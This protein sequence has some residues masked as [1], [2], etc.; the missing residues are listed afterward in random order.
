[1]TLTFPAGAALPGEVPM[2]HRSRPATRLPRSRA[3]RAFARIGGAFAAL[4]LP[5]SALAETPRAVVPE[6]A[7]QWLHVSDDGGLALRFVLDGARPTPFVRRG[8]RATA[9]GA[10]PGGSDL[11]VRTVPGGV[12]DFLVFHSAPALASVRY[13]VDVADWVGARFVGRSLER[14]DEAGT[15]RLRMAAPFVV[16]R[17]GVRHE[18]SV[19]LRECAAD[20]RASAPW[21]RAP[22]S[23]RA[24]ECV[25]DIAWSLPPA[26]YPAVLDPAWT[27]TA[28]LAEPRWAHGAARLEDGRVLVAGGSYPIGNLWGELASA[29]LYDP[30]TRTWAATGPMSVARRPGFTERLADGRVI[31]VGGSTGFPGATAQALVEVYDAAVGGFSRTADLVSPRFDFAGAKLLDGSVLVLGGF[32]TNDLATSSAERLDV[33]TLTWFEVAPMHE[34]RALTAATTLA[35]G[36]VLVSGG[37]DNPYL[38]GNV[39]HASAEL[40]DGAA[41][42]WDLLPAAMNTA[43]YGHT[44]TLVEGGRVLVTGGADGPQGITVHG[45]LELLDVAAATWSPVSANLTAPRWHHG[46]TLLPNG[47][48]LMVGGYSASFNPSTTRKGDLADVETG[49]LVALGEL[50]TPH[51]LETSTLLADGT[52]LV[53]GGLND[54]GSVEVFGSLDGTPC[55]AAAPASCANGRCE[56]GVCRVF[57]PM[58]GL[59]PETVIERSFLSC[60]LGGEQGE[61]PCRPTGLLWS[62]AFVGMACFRRRRTRAL[63]QIMGGR[64]A[65]G[66]RASKSVP[67]A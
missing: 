13:R 47:R 3:A 42:R 7:S 31:V 48:V 59:A 5:L 46:A 58:D 23:P 19:T 29:E 25:V 54:P 63:R 62:L 2:K 14:I 40:Y 9:R 45:S 30:S 65:I 66:P 15:P 37:G 32:I 56:S 12:E 51:T 33:E 60:S 50:A 43:R 34:K 52:V 8:D 49:S 61:S 1:M 11:V 21:G 18:A 26:A 38:T 53:V 27:T 6:L 57:E 22:V 35:D 20:T 64:G 4:A 41:D 16:D 28:R 44:A 17:H 24:A 39:V 55:D 67:A 36:R 10:G